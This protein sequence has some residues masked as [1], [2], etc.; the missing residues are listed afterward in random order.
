MSKIKADDLKIGD[1]YIDLSHNLQKVIDRPIPEKDLGTV[2]KQLTKTFMPNGKNIKGTRWE[3]EKIRPATREDFENYPLIE[4]MSSVDWEEEY[5]DLIFDEYVKRKAKELG[6]PEDEVPDAGTDE[7]DWDLFGEVADEIRGS[8]SWMPDP[9]MYMESKEPISMSKEDIM[10]CYINDITDVAYNYAPHIRQQEIDNILNDL[11]GDK[12]LDDVDKKFIMKMVRGTLLNRDIKFTEITE[13]RKVEESDK[14]KYYD[15]IQNRLGECNK[16]KD[17]ITIINKMSD[18]DLAK[19]LFNKYKE[20][21]RNP[22]NLLDDLIWGLINYLD[23]KMDGNTEVTEV[24]LEEDVDTDK[25][26]WD[27]IEKIVDLVEAEIEPDSNDEFD[28]DEHITFV[29]YRD[30]ED[31]DMYEVYTYL[32][33][34]IQEDLDTGD[35]HISDLD[36]TL[37]NIVKKLKEV[38]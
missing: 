1:I 14:N 26:I 5:F 37:V 23:K 19:E 17:I 25:D 24:T 7:F 18:K 34:Q 33:G 21:K 31:I 4:N 3:L 8:G 28:Y 2:R 29:F 12:D 20:L 6:I 10:S 11:K 38:N 32:D 16:E 30:L 13:S 9:D 22:L 35:V 15:T 27:K 36:N